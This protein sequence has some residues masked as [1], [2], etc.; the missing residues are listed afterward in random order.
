MDL[1]RV[2]FR[3][4]SIQEFLASNG[5]EIR[6]SSMLSHTQYVAIM[7]KVTKRCTEPPAAPEPLDAQTRLKQEKAARVSYCQSA[8]PSCSVVPLCRS[9]VVVRELAIHDATTN[10]AFTQLGHTQTPHRV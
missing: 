2:M 9:T 5:V 10:R 3:C 1:D 7:D 4:T 6:G 8:K